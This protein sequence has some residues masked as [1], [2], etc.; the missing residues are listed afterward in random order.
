EC[1]AIRGTDRPYLRAIRLGALAEQ[2]LIEVQQQLAFARPD[3]CSLHVRV[4]DDL[5]LLLPAVSWREHIDTAVGLWRGIRLFKRG[6][7]I[8]GVAILKDRGKLPDHILG[9]I[10]AEPKGVLGV[11]GDFL[12]DRQ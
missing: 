11:A 4:G 6:L 10:L 5:H 9:A 12:A 3:E 7:R 1:L 8:D 2:R